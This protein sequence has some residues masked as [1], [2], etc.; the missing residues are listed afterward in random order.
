MRKLTL[1][2]ML[3]CIVCLSA[4]TFLACGGNRGT[5]GLQFTPIHNTREYAVSRGTAT[6]T[7]IVIPR[8]YNRRPVTAIAHEGFR[9]FKE[10]TSIFIPNS[11]THFMSRSFEGRNFYNSGLVSVEFEEN[12]SL[13]GIGSGAFMGAANLESITIPKSVTIIHDRAFEDAANLVNVE[14]EKNSNLNTIN[15]RAFAGTGL[16]NITIPKSVTEIRNEAFRNSTALTTVEFEENSQLTAIGSL[17]WN[18]FYGTSL[19]SLTIPKSVTSISSGA[20]RNTTSLTEINVH[21][22]NN[23]FSS[24]NGVLFNKDKTV[25]MVYPSAKSAASFAIPHGVTLIN[26]Y[27]FQNA[28]YLK[29]IEIPNSVTHIMWYAFSNTGLTNVFIPD[30]AIEIATNA[31]GNNPN[32]TIV[33]FEDNSSLT[34][35]G[36]RVFMNSALTSIIIPNSVISMGGNVFWGSPLESIIFEY[37]SRLAAISHSAFYRLTSLTSIK[38]PASVQ[39]I[40][41]DAFRG[42]GLAYIVFENGSQLTEIGPSAFS[43]TNITSIKI[44]QGVTSIG[45]GAFLNTS[46]ENIVIPSNVTSIGFGAFRG[47]LNLLSIIIPI[48]VTSIGEQVWSGHPHTGGSNLTIFAEASCGY[49]INNGGPDWEWNIPGRPIIW[50]VNLSTC[51]TFVVS[52]LRSEDS[53]SISHAGLRISAPFRQGFTFGGW[54]TAY[55]NTTAAF[56][57]QNVYTAPVGTTLYAIWIAE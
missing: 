29:S 47:N 45:S 27:A 26:P 33:T 36:A 22:E 28:V 20:F 56:T 57:A 41:R 51:K 15:R 38:I 37:P 7:H 49:T 46:L 21:P 54:S 17:D 44:P 11:I 19:T 6:D 52:F 18:V 55:G 31:F 3:G 4:L 32:L 14:F 5:E 13:A 40:G 30:S 34:T 24:L 8:R 23:Y 25:L 50:G 42:S 12:S 53:I 1:L 48:S 10:L 16:T 2:A 43:G 39:H 9:D 35:L